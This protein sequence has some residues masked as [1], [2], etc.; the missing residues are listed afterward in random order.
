MLN[1]YPSTA[2]KA[3]LLDLMFEECGRAGYEFDR[4][5][6]EDASALRR[7]DALMAEWQ[8]QG[9]ALNYNF[10][11][12]FGQSQ[13]ADAAGIPDSAVNTVAAWGA[14]R[15]APGM[16]KS[17]SPETRKAMSDGLAFLRAETATI[18]SMKLPTTTG[19]G[20]GKKSWSV[21]YP[22]NTDQWPTDPIT[23][24]DVVPADTTAKAG[25]AWATTL[26]GQAEGA[27]LVLIN[28]VSGKYT[29]TG[30]LLS[31]VGLTAGTDA[32]V[33]RQV[34]PGAA[35]SPLDTT[36]AIVVS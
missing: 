33:V 34:L 9:I 5:P 26:S 14:M 7:L 35:N 11:A 2:T 29:L 15:I 13:P 22:F 31:G 1:P 12:T 24:V 21:W 23:L 18:P 4:S 32:P 8:A 17:I 16:G 20:I 3:V 6:G 28:S 10:P 30:N 19:M 27:Q 25:I 36:L